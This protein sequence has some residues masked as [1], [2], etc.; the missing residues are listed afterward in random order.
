MKLSFVIDTGENRSSFLQKI[1]MILLFCDFFALV[2]T[3]MPPWPVF[4]CMMKNNFE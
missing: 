2:F 4:Y 3:A 1:S